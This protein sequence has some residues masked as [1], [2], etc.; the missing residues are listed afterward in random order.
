MKPYYEHNGIVIY[1]GDCREVLPT[2]ESGSVDLVLTSPPYN[3]GK[4]YENREPLSVYID[5]QTQV[6]SEAVRVTSECGSI[7]WQVGHYVENGEVFPLDILLYPTF[8]SAGVKLRNR[9]VW[10]FGHGLH[11]QK[12]FSGRHETILWCTKGDDYTFNLDNVRVP[13][14]YP[15]KKHFKGPNKGQL[16]GNPLGKNP[17]DV[18][19]IANV[20]FNHPEKMDHPC[21]FPLVLAERLAR[22]L[23]NDNN[24]VLD[25]FM[26]SGTTLRAAK[27][28]GRRAIGIELKESYCEIAAKRLSQEVL[29][30]ENVA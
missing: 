5:W 2:I 11:C 9:I 1:H 7:C 15:N 3:V 27:D 12:R 22:A 30:T 16:S 21:Q 20:K 25:P 17:S 13:S 8:K 28:L 19:D 24:I 23:T 10:G 29:F 14:K 18:W 6:I 4:E 26:G